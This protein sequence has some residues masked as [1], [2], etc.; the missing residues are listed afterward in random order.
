MSTAFTASFSNLNSIFEENPFIFPSFLSSKSLIKKV[1]MKRKSNKTSR[2]KCSVQMNNCNLSMGYQTKLNWNNFFL[3][4][5]FDQISYDFFFNLKRKRGS[6]G[7]QFIK[8]KKK[9]F[10]VL[11]LF[12]IIKLFVSFKKLWKKFFS[13]HLRNSLLVT[14]I[15]LQHIKNF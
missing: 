10:P 2:E 13:Q 8:K 6:I 3:E 14:W 15:S 9:T 5:L 1:W 11:R 12:D 4:L 7:T